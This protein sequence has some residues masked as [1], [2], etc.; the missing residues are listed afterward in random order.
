[1]NYTKPQ[2]TVLGDAFRR[3]EHAPPA[4]IAPKSDS[5]LVVSTTNPAYDLD[6]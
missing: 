4:K 3:I 1:M 2:I 6:E 5:N